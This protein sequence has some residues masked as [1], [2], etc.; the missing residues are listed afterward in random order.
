[1]KDTDK[2]AIATVGR[3]L[4][5]S[6]CISLQPSPFFTDSLSL[7][8]SLSLYSAFLSLFVWF[9]YFLVRCF[10]F[11]WRVDFCKER[12]RILFV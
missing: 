6:S 10:S 12:K 3:F 11:F 1:D 7:S 8:L 2:R 4:N 5:Q 9:F